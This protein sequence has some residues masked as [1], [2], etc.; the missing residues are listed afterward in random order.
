LGIDTTPTPLEFKMRNTLKSTARIASVA[1]A[2][3]LLGTVVADATQKGGSGDAGANCRKLAQDIYN[4]Q[5]NHDCPQMNGATE[6]TLAECLAV[7]A[8]AYHEALK[9]CDG[10]DAEIHTAGGKIK[11]FSAGLS[12]TKVNAT[13]TG[14]DGSGGK[15]FDGSF[16]TFAGARFVKVN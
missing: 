12:Q 3:L 11:G 2:V 13:F 6:A 10:G 1:V 5:V 16:K 9:N 15:R 8:N 14:D 4:E 7:V